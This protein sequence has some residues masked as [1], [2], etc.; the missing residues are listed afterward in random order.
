MNATRYRVSLRDAAVP[1]GW[2]QAVAEA[3]AVRLTRIVC[4]YPQGRRELVIDEVPLAQAADHAARAGL[5][6]AEIVLGAIRLYD[7]RFR[8]WVEARMKAPPQ[9]CTAVVA[10]FDG[11]DR[12]DL[13]GGNWQAWD[14]Y[15]A[16]VAS[17]HVA[18]TAASWCWDP[19]APL[20]VRVAGEVTLVTTTLHHSQAPSPLVLPPGL[21]PGTIFYPYVPLQI[22]SAWPTEENT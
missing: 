12:P 2:V 16:A 8:P 5:S 3:C 7:E 21:L 10:Q 18:L 20:A 19:D 11:L 4:A 22:S 9:L 13:T 15:E 14:R 17:D 1:G 6:S